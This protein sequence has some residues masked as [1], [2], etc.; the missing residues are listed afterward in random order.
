M[1]ER[2]RIRSFEWSTAIIGTL[3]LVAGAIVYFRDG[4]AK[5][6]AIFTNDL[7]LFAGMLPKMGAGCLIA[8]F[9]TRL[10]PKEVVARVVGGESGLL[11]ILIAMG[12]GAVLPGGPLTI[13]PVAGAFLVL[14]ADAGT[15]VAFITAWNLLGYNRA[16]IWE[17]PFFGPEFVGWRIMLALPLPILAGFMARIAARAV[18]ARWGGD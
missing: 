15:A 12:M 11:G 2:R 3:S 1:A 14:G 13:Y 5:F 7:E 9:V 10:L 4:A 17:L 8:A 6:A 18:A 16:L